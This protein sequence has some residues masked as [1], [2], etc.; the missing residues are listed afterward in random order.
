MSIDR[1]KWR[2]H[3][4]RPGAWKADL[5]ILAVMAGLLFVVPAM[6]ETLPVEGA[7]LAGVALPPPHEPVVQA[8]DATSETC[9]IDPNEVPHDYD[10]P[11]VAAP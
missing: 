9:V 4:P 5:V 8:R 6:K 10:A 1:Y 2:D 7:H 3:V 11:P